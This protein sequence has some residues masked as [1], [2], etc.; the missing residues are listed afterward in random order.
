MWVGL[1]L[2]GHEPAYQQLADQIERWIISGEL[3]AGTTLPSERKLAETV[4]LSRITVQHSYNLLREKQLIRS[5]GRLGSI[6]GG[7]VQSPMN[8][9]RGFTEDMKEMGRTPTSVVRAKDV[10][11][12]PVIADAMGVGQETPFLRLNRHRFADGLPMSNERAW[13]NLALAPFLEQ[14]GPQASIYQ[15]LEEK[16]LRLTHCDQSVEAILPSAEENLLFGFADVTPCVLIKRTSYDRLG[17]ALEYVEGVF[18]G[19]LYRY[20]L[21]LDA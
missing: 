2:C 13:Y 15:C 14:A 19:D 1:A 8:R 21:R 18:R 12:D 5:Q 7:K 4:G 20:R 16:G 3:A 6:V 9:L 17:R 11:Q 10:V